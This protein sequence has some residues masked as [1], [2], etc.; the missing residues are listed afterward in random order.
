MGNWSF[1]SKGFYASTERFEVPFRKKRKRWGN[2]KPE[3][4]QTENY[5]NWMNRIS[6]NLMLNSVDLLTTLLSRSEDF[7]MCEIG[8]DWENLPNSYRKVSVTSTGRKIDFK[9][10]R[11]DDILN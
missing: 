3:P 11:N 6:L 8:K 1:V 4:I 9:T 5:Q 2:T 10:L 7:F